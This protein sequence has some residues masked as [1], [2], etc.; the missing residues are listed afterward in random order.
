MMQKILKK[1]I[2]TTVLVWVVYLIVIIFWFLLLFPSWWQE[3]TLPIAIFESL[4]W[5][6]YQYLPVLHDY[7]INL[8]QS[9][10]FNFLTLNEPFGYGSFF[11]QI[12]ALVSIQYH[13]FYFTDS[14]KI[15]LILRTITF[16]CQISTLLFV[17]LILK[18]ISHK[19]NFHWVAI[20]TL[21][22]LAPMNGLLLYYKPFSPD[23]LITLLLIVSIYFL[24]CFCTTKDVKKLHFI[25]LITG[26]IIFG[27]AVGSK[28]YA[29]LLSP[30]LLL[31]IFW[32][33]AKFGKIFWHKILSSIILFLLLPIGFTLSNLYILQTGINSYYSKL[34]ILNSG[35]NI[36]DFQHAIQPPGLISRIQHWIF[37]PTNS[38][39]GIDTIGIS[40]EYIHVYIYILLCI[41]MV[42]LAVK[43]WKKR[44]L[45]PFYLAII[46]GIIST[47]CIVLT[48]LTTNRVWTW[49]LL[50]FIYILAIGVG[51]VAYYA[52]K[53]KYT[54][55]A[56]IFILSLH[57]WILLPGILYEVQTAKEN[58][59][60][61]NERVQFYHE[62]IKP[63]NDVLIKSSAH[64]AIIKQFRSPTPLHWNA[65]PCWGEH[66]PITC[67]N[68]TTTH[69][70]QY[71]FQISAE[72]EK[73]LTTMGFKNIQCSPNGS[74]YYR[75]N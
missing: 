23:Y 62:C 74:I 43:F 57:W 47:G 51:G 58:L 9:Q 45:E 75:D 61:A 54:I 63:Y 4:S 10:W 48:V 73:Q 65:R 46:L 55:V 60:V 8:L 59:A 1:F 15:L 71:G 6:E 34:Q 49:Y 30:I 68:Q 67:V 39:S 40:Y 52:L 20:I 12:Y 35:M 36:N 44:Y 17:V 29:I 32:Q 18:R 13:D 31:P 56:I 3:S 64:K 2:N 42:M 22:F 72:Q 26:Y 28:P 24:I 19:K 38:Y 69:I 41:S 25:A 5:D 27:M 11:W 21:L 16:I 14:G 70:I 50:P 37:S 33:W 7:Q 53:N 66:N